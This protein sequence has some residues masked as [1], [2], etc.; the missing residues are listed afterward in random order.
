VILPAGDLCVIL[1]DHGSESMTD[2][3][4]R[5]ERAET[6][7]ANILS[8]PLVVDFVHL[9]PKYMQSKKEL[10]LCDLLIEDAPAALVVQLKT[11]D[12][13]Q[14]RSPERSIAWVRKQIK[15]ASSQ[16]SGSVR[17]LTRV[18][19]SSQHPLL[20]EVTFQARSL[21]ARHGVVVVDYMGEPIPIDDSVPRRTKQSVPIHY[22]AFED[23]MILCQHLHTLPDLINYLDERSKIPAWATPLIGDEKNV[24]GYY[25]THRGQFADCVT[26]ADFAGQWDEL[27][28]THSIVYQEKLDE[29]EKIGVFGEILRQIHNVDLEASSYTPELVMRSSR[30]GDSP[31]ERVVISRHLN[32]LRGVHRRQVI[33]LLKEK[34]DKADNS[35]LGFNYFA[36][37][38]DRERAV[39]MYLFLASRHGRSERINQ[40]LNMCVCLITTQ[41][42]LDFV[43]GVA[44]DS[45][46]RAR[47]TGSSFNYMVLDSEARDS[48]P[49]AIEN[50]RKLFSKYRWDTLHDF[51]SEN[52]RIIM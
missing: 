12:P 1:Y 42:D 27:T 35:S 41:T 18:Q 32:R 40:L 5:G 14:A 25:T 30:G 19:V 22:L 11:Q 10:E 28:T 4:P 34:M 51:P 38:G 23:L 50:C 36:Y 6:L 44:T 47:N 49:E 33:D 3:V 8:E 17:T 39:V 43:V 20:G 21:A 31:A 9:R 13:Q 29:D 48:D 26:S 24:Y 15:K 52:R 16:V 37:S 46:V 7:L 2:R 45:S